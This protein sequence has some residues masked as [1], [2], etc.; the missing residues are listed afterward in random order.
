MTD[1]E[2]DHA[3]IQNSLS[4]LFACLCPSLP[5][6]FGK[7]MGRMGQDSS[8]CFSGTT[9]LLPSTISAA[10]LM[11]PCHIAPALCLLGGEVCTTPRDLG[12]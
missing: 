5:F 3:F 12:I 10:Y 4:K 7:E 8:F 11:H 9:A 2:K 6:A 1:R